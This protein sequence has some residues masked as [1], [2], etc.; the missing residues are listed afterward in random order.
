M[1]RTAQ[2]LLVFFFL[3]FTIFA[4][5]TTGNLEGW[6]LDVNGTAVVGAEVTVTSPSLQGMR[7]ISTDERG[8]F[9]L[10]GLPSGKYTVTVRHLSYLPATVK[11]VRVWLGKTT[12]VAEVRLQQTSVQMAEVVVSG[13]R[14]LLDPSSATSGANLLRENFEV[15]PI[16]RNY[17][18][19]ASI[20]PH[21]NS[22]YFGDEVNVAGATGLENKSF[23][24]GTDVSDALMGGGGTNLPY[25]FIR[26]IE[27]KT[28]GYEAE[29]K[30]SLG[31]IIN[32]ITY[33]GGNEFSGQVF[34]F[35]TNNRFGGTP[36]MA[37]SEPPQN[38][39]MH[40]DF[41]MTLGGPIVRDQLW[42]FTALNPKVRSEDIR[43]PGLGY[44]ADRTNSYAFAGKLSWRA[45]GNLDV[46]GTILGDPTT[47]KAVKGS[48]L[49]QTELKAMNADP[50]L[51]DVTGGGYNVMLDTRYV[52]GNDL[53]LQGSASWTA[54]MSKSVPS[55]DRGVTERI[56]VDYIAGTISGGSDGRQESTVSTGTAKISV[57]KLFGDHTLKAGIEYREVRLDNLSTIIGYNRNSDSSYSAVDS[58]ANGRITNQ[59]PS[60][61]IQDSWSVSKQVRISG[62][63]RWD[64]L[65]VIAS[66]GQLVTRVLKQF[67][68]RLGIVFMPGNDESQKYFASIGR[69]AEDL[70]L[71]GSSYV[72]VAGAYQVARTFD[73]DPRLNH[74]GGDTA[75]SWMSAIPPGVQNVYGQYY[76]ELN[77]GVEHLIGE[78]FKASL[79]GTYRTLRQ[80]IEDGSSPVDGQWY[81][82]NPGEEN[83]SAYPHPRREYLA[84]EISLEKSWGNTFNLLCSFV[85][86]RNS[87]NYYGWYD[88]TLNLG[89]PGFSNQF[90]FIDMYREH[91]VGLL[92]N[93]RTHVFK[94]NASYRLDVGLTCGASFLWESGTPLSEQA[95]THAPPEGL[96][97]RFLVQR[98][99]SGRLPALWDLN[100]RLTYTPTFWYL[101]GA[102]PRFIMDVFHL[103]S[104]RT[105]VKQDELRYFNTDAVSGN[106]V[107]PNPSFGLPQKFQPPMSMRLGVEV[108]F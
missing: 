108:S 46:T 33:S 67:Q 52:A 38:A 92:P 68:P 71:L 28:G 78:D 21:A 83:L 53:I 64:G 94:V 1:T 74:S 72:H 90:D 103:G 97:R 2:V 55:T 40:Y 91:S 62:G 13:A 11:N 88:Q 106:P 9:R 66:N 17:R 50:F 44:Y 32:G 51:A 39:F 24:D 99:S 70:T 80:I 10:L 42:F 27:V 7:G 18:S 63:L 15:L 79:K 100:V 49:Y 59:I 47:K 31:G 93:D 3:P 14:P 82:S 20:L 105:V 16:D 65:S 101:A 77:L 36:R 81:Y 4:Q 23:I 76:D 12:T 73:H 89:S 25:N 30:S 98:G 41:G 107:G 95:G 57:T 69:Y 61:F 56:F 26:E 48:F 75:W 60:G 102:K 87:G 8:F 85:L 6:I 37:P 34:G 35:F 22:S 54:N 96:W 86:S 43:I 104:Q 45:A 58:Y 19:L 84:L 29:Y 5:S